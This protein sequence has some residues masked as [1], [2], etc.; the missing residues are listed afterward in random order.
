MGGELLQTNRVDH[1]REL[2]VKTPV[3]EIMRPA[4][5]VADSSEP[6]SS[7]IG[8]MITE[9]VYVIPVLERKRYIGLLDS[10]AIIARRVPVFTKAKHMVF[11][12]AF[13]APD[14]S[15][16]KAVHEMAADSVIALPVG[17]K[18]TVSG[19][20]SFWDL[21]SWC[22]LQSDFSSL[23]VESIP[24]IP[25]PIL[26]GKTHA[27]VA[28]MVLRDIRFSQLRIQNQKTIEL[29]DETDWVSHVSRLPKERMTRGEKKGE[30]IKRLGVET[31]SFSQP[32]LV[33]I[34]PQ[35]SIRTLLEKWQRFHGAYAEID[36]HLLTFR[37]FLRFLESLQPVL[38]WNAKTVWV[39][40]RQLD[41][42]DR[43][44]MQKLLHRFLDRFQKRF[45]Y[46]ALIELRLGFKKT[47]NQG[48]QHVLEQTAN[49][50]TARG[51]F[52]AKKSGWDH[53]AVFKDLLGV[54]WRE[55]Q[56]KT[57]RPPPKQSK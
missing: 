34:Q 5:V 53:L 55:L 37:D 41:S 2:L 9:N 3:R 57:K 30:K 13:L 35:N 39:N 48:E 56:A 19:I 10:Q 23:R 25:V 27:D 50:M 8:K 49:L 7:V 51:S 38:D 4:L 29:L 17:Q 33:W 20:V 18:K 21:I 24:Y 54:L 31:R 26:P 12:P 45:G 11:H 42:R 44:Q 52:V 1:I 28:G 47:K 32:T 15:L 43:V 40:I 22:L 16:A 46:D 14:D 36:G 6:I